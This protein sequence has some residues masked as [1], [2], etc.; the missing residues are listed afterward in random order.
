[1]Y[2]NL[3]VIVVAYR[4]GASGFFPYM[5]APPSVCEYLSLSFCVHSV[6]KMK[7]IRE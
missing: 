6:T 2:R 7:D 5:I 4:T 3:V 1:M